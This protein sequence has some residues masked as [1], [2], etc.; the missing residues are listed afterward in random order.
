[1]LEGVLHVAGE[2]ARRIAT[3]EV[4]RLEH[5]QRVVDVVDSADR[6]ED[7]APERLADDR[8]RA[9]ARCARGRH[10]VDARGDRLAHRDRQIVAV[11]ELG[12]GGGELLEEE[13][14]SAGDLDERVEVDGCAPAAAMSCA[15]SASRLPAAEARAGSSSARRARR[16]RSAARRA[17]PAAQ[18]RSA[19]RA[20]RARAARGTRAARARCCP[21]SGC[22]RRGRRSAARGRHTRRTAARRRRGAAPAGLVVRREP[23]EEREITERLGRLGF[24]HEL[25]DAR[26]RASRARPPARPTR[27]SRRPRARAA[28]RPGSRPAPRTGGS[29]RAGCGRRRR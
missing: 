15:A 29:G 2:L 6:V 1:M 12:D 17:A 25:A 27:G 16:P 10:R 7:A 26:A 19:A 23:E 18:R 14:I 21:P 13:R 24:R 11:A 22:P 4:A 28:R 8:R 3:D 9:E 5:V 20:R